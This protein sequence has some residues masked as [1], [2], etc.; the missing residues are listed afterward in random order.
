MNYHFFNK[1]LKIIQYKNII[2]PYINKFNIFAIEK[3]PNQLQ[4]RLQKRTEK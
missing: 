4:T 2:D 1:E 3:S